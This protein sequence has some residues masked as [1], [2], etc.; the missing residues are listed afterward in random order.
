[1]GTI[2]EYQGE[3]ISDSVGDERDDLYQALEKEGKVVG[4]FFY[5]FNQYC[6]ERT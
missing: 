2:A 6:T 1:M 3:L 4:S 5:F